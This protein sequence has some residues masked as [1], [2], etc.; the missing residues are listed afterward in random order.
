MSRNII[1]VDA[2]GERTIAAE[3]LPLKIGSQANA[4]VRVPGAVTEGSRLL[5]D[6]L[7]DR[8]FLQTVSSDGV[9]VNGEL[10]SK[11]RWLKDGDVIQV[12]GVKISCAFDEELRLNVDVAALEYPTLPPEVAA[13]GVEP[14]EPITPVRPRARLKEDG[15]QG[16]AGKRIKYVGLGALGV[17]LVVAAY[18]FTA[19]AVLIDVEP[20]DAEIKVVGGLFAPKIGGRYLL[21]QR[22]YRVLLNADGY[23]SERQ[24]IEV[25]DAP[26]QSFEFVM[27][28]LPGRVALTTSPAIEARVFV[29]G[30]ELGML[31]SEA[32]LV[33]PGEH[34]VRVVAERYLEFETM[35]TVEGR[36]MLQTV[37]VELQPGWGDVTLASTPAAAE[38]FVDEEEI[39]VTP[40]TLPIMAGLR[41]L[42]VRKDGYKAWK[43]E[44]TVEAG[45]PIEIPPVTLVEADGLLTVI[46]VPAGAAVSVD[47]RYRGTTPVEVELA[48][49]R[50]Y[51]VIASK[52]GFGTVS[53]TIKLESR[54]GRTLRLP[55]EPRLGILRV[56]ADPPDA[57]LFVDGLSRGPANQELSLPARP[58]KI[59]IRKAGFAPFITEISTQPGMPENLEVRLLTPQE[60]VLAA[61]PS[62]ITTADG[63]TLILVR[64]G[65]EFKMG[66]PRREQGRR[67]N[68]AQHQVKL[69]RPF[70]LATVEVSNSRF[71]AFKPKHTSGAEK[72]RQLATGN[73]PAVML[74]W[75][76]AT[77]Y[78]NWLSSKDGL[79]P[80]YIFENG[81]IALAQP[82]TTGYRLPTEAEWAWAA[83]FTGGGGQ[84]KYPWGD[85]MPP[86]EGAGNFA[87]QSA[88]AVLP[89]ALSNYND[90]F[91]IT[92]PVGS[93]VPNPIG[94][95]DLGGNVAEWVNDRYTVYTQ[96]KGV[97]IDPL[98]PD[99]GQYHV[100]RGSGWRHSSI[101]ELRYAYRDFG[102]RG[103]LDVG[104]RIARY[105]EP[106]PE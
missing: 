58:H 77:G 23:H 93:F 86:P 80:A 49:G 7:D 4:D 33:E 67:P 29:D 103:R 21:R 60:A 31:P 55:L 84:V 68:E 78:C 95:Y 88:R 97:Q 32:F 15:E 96:P 1:V 54:A 51:E 70:Y 71:Q 94:I 40:A 52:A 8:A 14:P 59:E 46:T 79:P 2:N 47:G 106:L 56:R 24:E 9:E 76:E 27:R 39:G 72:Y 92:A 64:P 38:I 102:D 90:R 48:P 75:E 74:S 53:R 18:L 83:R 85:R 35:V 3:Q 16:A 42:V 57:E 98:G 17:L 87:D 69:A 6:L 12:A 10:V 41:Q 26:N 82:V 63:Q 34:A 91:A 81:E 73:H 13:V 37:E 25:I 19:Q 11:N 99:K 44:V 50:N 20:A 100:I 5:I 61:T 105:A 30:E 62:T 22:E 66:A 36:G 101:S 43:K 65:G 104:F 28:K 45:V 89:N